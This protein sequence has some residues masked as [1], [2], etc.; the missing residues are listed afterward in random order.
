MQIVRTS[1]LQKHLLIQCTAKS[2]S[3]VAYLLLLLKIIVTGYIK[4]LLADTAANVSKSSLGV[5]DQQV[6]NY[7][8]AYTGLIQHYMPYYSLNL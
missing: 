2:S 6:P 4:E 8:P 5:Q 7:L 3:D 1:I